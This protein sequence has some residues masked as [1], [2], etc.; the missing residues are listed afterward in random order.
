MR[1][2]NFLHGGGAIKRSNL[3]HLFSI[4]T[5]TNL[6][7]R[8]PG[9]SDLGLFD[10]DARTPFGLLYATLTSARYFDPV[11]DSIPVHRIG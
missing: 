2:C 6:N 11:I 4:A 10:L 5:A 3:D 7:F 8:G 1:S 9:A